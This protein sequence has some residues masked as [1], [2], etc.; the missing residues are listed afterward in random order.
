MFLQYCIVY[1]HYSVFLICAVLSDVK[2]YRFFTITYIIMLLT[3]KENHSKITSM[4]VMTQNN[5]TV[6]YTCRFM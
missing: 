1:E 3:Y 2:H 4:R 6:I 5:G